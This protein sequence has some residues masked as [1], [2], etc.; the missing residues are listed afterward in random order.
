LAGPFAKIGRTGERW[1]LAAVFGPATTV[2]AASEP[3]SLGLLAVSMLVLLRRQRGV[4]WTRN[5]SGIRPSTRV[6]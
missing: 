2:V 6:C 3:G 4:A 5:F 1:P